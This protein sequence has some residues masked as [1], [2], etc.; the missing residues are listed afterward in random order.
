MSDIRDVLNKISFYSKSSAP[1]RKQVEDQ[2]E[3]RR[4]SQGT[5]LFNKGDTC[6]IVGLVGKGRIR[7]SKMSQSGRE[8]TLYHVEPGEGCVLNLSCAFANNK[9]PATAVVEETIDQVVFP[10]SIFQNWLVN[11]DVR[12]FV[13]DL[14]SNRLIKVITLIEE[15]VFRKM[16]QR[17]TEFL[18]DKFE[19]NGRPIR[20]IHLTQEQIASNLGTA[21]EVINRLI[22]EL[23]KAGAVQSSRGKITLLDE[24]ALTKYM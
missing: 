16:D 12:A 9:Y 4:I 5:P 7:V 2:G 18:L 19:N 24:D 23:E 1:F 13:F 14:F 10:T 22:K 11:D 15:I 3:Y 17:L 21:R 6:S 20:Y 8:V